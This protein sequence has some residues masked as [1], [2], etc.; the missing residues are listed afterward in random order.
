LPCKNSPSR[1]FRNSAPLRVTPNYFYSATKPQCDMADP[2]DRGH[3]EQDVRRIGPGNGPFIAE[4]AVREQRLPA[5][6]RAATKAG[7]SERTPDVDRSC[8]GS[9][10]GGIENGVTMPGSPRSSRSTFQEGIGP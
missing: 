7:Q 1:G 9:M 5:G 8:D 10:L 3:R 6:G 2:D 4:D